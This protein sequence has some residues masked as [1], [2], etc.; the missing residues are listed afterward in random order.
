MIPMK[1]SKEIL[2]TELPQ[3][4]DS[5]NT[6]KTSGHSGIAQIKEVGW[7]SELTYMANTDK[8]DRYGRYMFH[9][10]RENP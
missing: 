1:N 5:T 2:L 10:L 9:Y 3:P 4:N 6:R 8:H 7:L